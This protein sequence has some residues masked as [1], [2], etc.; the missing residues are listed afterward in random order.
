M[1]RSL[2]KALIIPAFLAIPGLTA[3]PTIIRPVAQSVDSCTVK[4]EFSVSPPNGLTIADSGKLTISPVGQGDPPSYWSSHGVNAVAYRV[5]GRELEFSLTVS[6]SPDKSWALP[7]QA[8]E[9]GSGLTLVS[10]LGQN[11]TT[12]AKSAGCPEPPRP[13]ASVPL[14]GS[15]NVPANPPITASPQPGSAAEQKKSTVPSA[16]QPNGDRSGLE[17]SV[18]LPIKNTWIQRVTL[19]CLLLVLLLGCSNLL[20]AAFLA[21]GGVYHLV[22]RRH[23]LRVDKPLNRPDES[24]L[25]SAARPVLPALSSET[26]PVK[27][28]EGP[29]TDSVVSRDQQE[30]AGLEQSL[31]A[32]LEPVAKLQQELQDLEKSMLERLAALIGLQK[33]QDDERTKRVALQDQVRSLDDM[34]KLL[35]EDLKS[36]SI[37]YQSLRLLNSGTEAQQKEVAGIANRVI[38]QK[39]DLADAARGMLPGSQVGSFNVENRDELR[40]DSRKDIQTSRVS[41]GEIAFIRYPQEDDLLVFPAHPWALNSRTYSLLGVMFDGILSATEQDRVESIVLAARLTP[42]SM[43]NSYR[44]SARGAIQLKGRPPVLQADSNARQFQNHIPLAKVPES[45]GNDPADKRI[46]AL[47]GE[48]GIL[49]EEYSQLK[50]AYAELNTAFE[51]VKKDCADIKLSH[52]QL[53]GQLEKMNDRLAQG[54]FPGRMF[55]GG[56]SGDEASDTQ[57]LTANGEA[58]QAADYFEVPERIPPDVSADASKPLGPMLAPEPP[59]TRTDPEP[60][61][62]ADALDPTGGTEDIVAAVARGSGSAGDKLSSFEEYLLGLDRLLAAMKEMFGDSARLCATWRAGAGW[63]VLPVRREAGSVQTEDPPDRLTLTGGELRRVFCAVERDNHLYGVL[64]SGRY[65]ETYCVG[66]ADLLPVDE[67]DIGASRTSVSLGQ[68]PLV[69]SWIGGQEYQVIRKLK[70]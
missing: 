29:Q 22:N 41:G 65:W 35:S 42:G 52:K 1:A 4:W 5:N 6:R 48:L 64:P 66:L 33:Q 19:S 55:P 46:D 3:T 47:R 62:A 21:I 17:F 25:P 67:D 53:S 15:Q 11:W 51:Q 18:V 24:S 16:R 58:G 43:G 70:L 32:R 36:V 8:V 49:G 63:K 28:Q 10:D 31:L 12:L 14:A 59:S 60:Q 54:Q 34:T 30:Q 7:F 39:V 44:V 2:N 26:A 69:L 50:K 20:L 45:R 61:P 57:S 56:V 23:R 38:L 9:P 68:R 40:S 13:A 27:T 37:A